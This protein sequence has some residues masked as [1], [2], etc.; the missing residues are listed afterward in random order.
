MEAFVLLF[1]ILLKLPDWFQYEL[2]IW[3]FIICCQ[4]QL[5]IF[6]TLKIQLCGMYCCVAGW[7]VPSVLF[8]PSKYQEPLIQWHIVTFLKT[9]ILSDISVRTSDIMFYILFFM[10]LC[11][12][13]LIVHEIPSDINKGETKYAGRI[14]RYQI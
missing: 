10:W 14:V 11:Q 12:H 8:I 13:Y 5:S 1:L 2:G 3:D 4:I 9:C 6:Y 7:V